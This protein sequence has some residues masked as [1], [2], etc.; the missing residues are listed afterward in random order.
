MRGAP[1][2]GFSWLIRRI[3]SRR[4][5]SIRD[6]PARFRDFQRQE[7]VDQ[8]AFVASQASALVVEKKKPFPYCE[9]Q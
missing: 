9:S 5:R 3:R 8:R 6:R 2:S 1:Q 7:L 4:S